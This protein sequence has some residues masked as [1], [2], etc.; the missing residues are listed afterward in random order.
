MCWKPALWCSGHFHRWP[1]TWIMDPPHKYEETL[2]GITVGKEAWEQ[3]TSLTTYKIVRICICP[4]FHLVSNIEWF[5]F[6]CLLNQLS[7]LTWSLN[8]RV[9][10]ERENSSQLYQLPWNI[11]Q[12]INIFDQARFSLGR[13]R[14]G[15]TTYTLEIFCIMKSMRSR[16]SSQHFMYFFLKKIFGR[17]SWRFIGV[18]SFWSP[19]GMGRCTEM[20]RVR[21]SVNARKQTW[22]S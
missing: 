19:V 2:M 21:V 7:F 17:L 8:I 20:V 6:K 13:R 10:Y 9:G 12:M 5:R 15:R 18:K 16:T 1:L 4:G 3:R 22:P 11:V 14:T